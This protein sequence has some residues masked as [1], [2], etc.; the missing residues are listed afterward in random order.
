M[1]KTSIYD[2]KELRQELI[3]IELKEVMQK[4]KSNGYNPSNQI[5]G[6]IL[7][8]DDLYITNKENA[9]SIIKKYD[10]RELLSALLNNCFEI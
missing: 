8:G 9:R 10:R 1:D 7:T 4:L 5:I 6:Y 3:L 2:F